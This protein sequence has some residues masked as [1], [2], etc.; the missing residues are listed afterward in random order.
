MNH[1]K[2]IAAAALAVTL[3][4]AIGQVQI[5]RSPLGSGEP[6]Q[7]GLENATLVFD[8]VYH[9]PQYM[10]GFPTAATLWP[11]VVEVPCRRVGAGLQCDGYNWT[12]RMGRAEYLFF[13]PVLVSGTPVSITDPPPAPVAATGKQDAQ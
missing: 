5:G 9:V 6:G 7:S 10:P 1:P 3:A 12:P 11:R 8:N 13:V 2:F 4:P